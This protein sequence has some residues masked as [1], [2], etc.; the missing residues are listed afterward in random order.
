MIYQ[1]FEQK[2][3]ELPEN[4]AIEEG[5][6]QITYR[7]LNKQANLL[8]YLLR[9]L[10]VEKETIISVFIPSSVQLVASLL[11]IFKAGGIYLPLDLSFA[12]K[13]IQQIFS[14]TESKILVTNKALHFQVEALLQ[15]LNI[16]IRYLIVVDENIPQVYQDCGT[17]FAEYPVVLQYAE[18]N[19]EPVVT[20][21]DSNYIFYTSG[22]TGEAKAILGR[23]KGLSHFI[24]WETQE[25][26][27]DSSC[28]VSQLVQ[29]TFD[30]SLRDIFVPLTT[31][32]TLCIPAEDL[33]SNTVRLVQW[34]ENSGISLIHCVPSLFRLISKEVQSDKKYYGC[35]QSLK[36]ILMAGELLY[37]KDI[38]TWREALGTYVELVNLYGPTE[39]TM[40]KTFHRIKDVPAQPAQPL[41]V[42]KPISNTFILILN[43]NQLCRIGERGEIYIKTPFITQGYFKN[44]ELTQ[45]VFV[46]N[47]LIKD[48]VD[49]IYRTGDIGRYLPDMSVEV[50]GRIDEQVKVNG[51]RVELN[52]I[53]QAVLSKSGVSEVVVM[54]H[55]NNH[56]NQ[57]ELVCYYSG[58]QVS[59]EALREFL[60][61]ELNQNLIPAYF[62]QLEEF[63]LNI[64]GK[65]D[66]KALPKPDELVINEAD[67]EASQ[68]DPELQLESIWQEI[69]NLKRI[70]RN[71]SFFRIGGTSLKATQL[72]SRIFKEFNVSIRIADVFAAPTIGQLA[73]AIANAEKKAYAQ[74]EAISDTSGEYYDLSHGQKRL[75]ILNQFEGGQIAYNMPGAFVLDGNLHT[76][77]FRQAFKTIIER[78]ESL[79]TTFVTIDGQP[80]QHIQYPANYP[81]QLE[82]LDL[83]TDRQAENIVQELAGAD[84][85]TP[86][87]LENGPLLRAKLIQLRP[88]KFVVLF[89][90]HHIISDGWSMEVL[91][92]EMLVLY[93]AYSQGLANPLAPLRIQYKDYAAWQIRQLGEDK[94][95]GHQTYWRQQLEGEIPIL[96]LPTDFQRPVVKTYTGDNLS[97][98][99]DANSSSFLQTISQKQECSLFMTLLASVKALLFRYT[100]QTDIIIGSPIAGR[101]HSD[102]ENQIGFYVNTLALRTRFDGQDSF[103]KL[104]SNVK[105]VTLGAYEHQVYPFD[106]LVDDLQL[107]KDLSRTPLFDVM[108]V[109]QNTEVKDLGVSRMQGIHVSEL[110]A[111]TTISKFD[112]KFNFHE[113]QGQIH[114]NIEYNT[115]L[116]RKARIER[117][118]KHFGLLL[119]AF[120]EDS[121]QAINQIDYLTTEEKQQLLHNFNH[122]VTPYSRHKTIHQLLEE[123]A[124]R[125][126]DRIALRQDGLEL[127][128]SELNSRSN[129]LARYLLDRGVQNGDNIGVI[130]GRNFNMIIG[131]YAIM[132]ANAAYVPID[133]VYPVDRQQ[134]IISNSGATLVLVDEAYPIA[135]QFREVEYIK[136]TEGVYRGFDQTN[137]NLE[138]D[139]TDLAYTIYTS[140]STGRPK[141]VMIEH[142]SAVN[143]I[144]WVNTTFAVGPADR[145]LFITSMCFD[146]SVYDIFGILAA[147][148]LVVI[149]HQDEVQNV[150]RLQKLLQDE[151]ITF[152]DSVPTTMNYLVAELEAANENYIQ[153]DLR[154]V[155]MSGDWIP[156]N[157]PT[158]MKKYFPQVQPISLGGATEGTVW[159]NFYP[160]HHVQ[161]DWLSIPYG[162][163]IAN[164]FF[165]ILDENRNP[166]PQ[167]VAGE[168]YIGGVGVARGYA[169]DPEKTDYSYKEDRFNSEL[170]GRMYRTGDLGRMREDGNMEF[171][172]RKDHQVKI[173]GFRVELG[174]IKNVLLQHTE[175]KEVVVVAKEDK[176]AGKYLLAYFTG[177]TALDLSD[178]KAFLRTHLPEY[179]VPAHLIGLEKLPLTSN[180]KIDLKSLP[181]PEETLSGGVDYV[182]PKTELEE[183]LVDI[184]E[185][186]L[187]REKIG[188]FDDFFLSGG[189][190]IK[191]IQ[192]ASRLYKAGYLVRVADIFQNSYIH[193]LAQ[194][195]RKITVVAG[196]E[197]IVGEVSLVPIQKDFFAQKRKAPH[198]Y[199]VPILLKGEA[200][201]TEPMVRAIFSKIWQHH[202]A[203]RMTF[204]WINGEVKGLVQ[205]PEIPFNLDIFDYRKE[206][207]AQELLTEKAN[208]LQTTFDLENGPLCRLALFHLPEGDRL[209]ILVH[210]L[211]IDIVAGR[212]LIEDI[213]SLY[214]QYGQGNVLTLPQKTH[215]VKQWAEKLHDYANSEAFLQEKAYWKA[216]EEIQTIPIS[217]DFDEASN[218]IRDK[219]RFTFTLSEADTEILLTNVSAK[220]QTHLP[221]ILLTVIGLSI[222]D[223]FSISKVPVQLI[224]HGREEILPDLNIQRTIGW[225]SNL[226][227][228][229]V[230]VSADLDL[231]RQVEKCSRHLRQIP[232]SGMGYGLLKYLTKAEYK[233]DL[234]FNIQPQVSFNFYG[235]FEDEKGQDS[236]ILVQEGIGYKDN[237]DDPRHIELFDFTGLI[238]NKRLTIGIGYNRTHFLPDTVLTLLESYQLYLEKVVA[239]CQTEAPQGVGVEV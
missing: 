71:A 208:F 125:A 145:M 8:A 148:G 212:V 126:P 116:F 89:T 109:L 9:D 27:L 196:Q 134:Y 155:F 138:K 81:L 142:H 79:R 209:L 163:P 66:K 17:G 102:L 213:A 221:D 121:Q 188:T 68:G 181:A 23:H 24:R 25:F 159:S 5:E 58:E 115:D 175:V 146:L 105:S 42:G 182:A 198:H 67:Y 152:W 13:R 235:Q 87:D 216:Q 190:S 201:F 227:P 65:V 14:Q 200:G 238:T 231:I 236:I 153:K 52:E 156:V 88:D 83:Q 218:A 195:L 4:V 47:P 39:T 223:T 133:P 46:Q 56:D 38:Q 214:K 237:V 72:I 186:V 129:Q 217:K 80:R 131:M 225:F 64:N 18:A 154:L 32:G 233:S 97:F 172:G 69:L 57:V 55:K 170:G 63:P 167:G 91:I 45:T 92:N 94:I 183:Q 82:F 207:K 173:R 28:K 74:I 234:A 219:G 192:I 110:K 140:G 232:N 144:E 35:L 179:M 177:N 48:R 239:A 108:V 128:Y 2:V 141:G 90:M 22:S 206:V 54:A 112:L 44:P 166:V 37:A 93:D 171:L 176:A 84:A 197:A 191:A 124:Y 59:Q 135:E 215:S 205:S 29:Y 70:G 1:D 49:T 40:V 118:V 100:H 86:F 103:E 111:Q 202:D 164:N 194:S 130:A 161:P 158:R 127:T 204:Q 160:I 53:R 157:L 101:S 21:E 41:H 19:P 7:V 178:L 76:G 98:V 174:E 51:I 99:L 147:G 117:M 104:L 11:A 20:P 96:E 193:K 113:D 132:K 12:K 16:P 187:N 50:L 136:L 224:G 119:Q 199:N 36:H 73:V 31:G 15:E 60:Q 62:V 169:N 6:K 122:T 85:T 120:A 222:R 114:V 95:K 143:L 229:L 184:W 151:R 168:L 189:D 106:R 165:Y 78:H 33:K 210:H 34:I 61:G 107:P 203:L 226:Y 162:K 230:D 149:A 3:A 123:Q 26:K 30:A 150:V 10:G 220:F 75:W 43:N 185:N 228:V 180:G 211:V 77:A 139:T 137:L